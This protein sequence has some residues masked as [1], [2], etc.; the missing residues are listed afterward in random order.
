MYLFV[1][2]Y[3]FFMYLMVLLLQLLAD[4]VLYFVVLDPRFVYLL[5]YYTVMSLTIGSQADSHTL[6][7]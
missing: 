6:Q 2:Y 4:F 3:L 1:F 5:T 7:S